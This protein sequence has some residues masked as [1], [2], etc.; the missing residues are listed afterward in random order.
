MKIFCDRER[1]NEAIAVVSRAVATKSNLAAV[2]G[3]LLV[4]ENDSLTLTGYDFETGIKTTFEC[5]IMREGS[6]VLSSQLL[7]N[8]VR[9]VTSDEVYIE[10]DDSMNCVIKAG[11]AQY[12]IKGIDPDTYPEF[13]GGVKDNVVKLEKSLFSEMVDH[14]I[15][16]VSTDQKRPVHTGVLLQM[17]ESVLTMV[18]TDGYRLAICDRNMDFEGNFRMVV[19]AKA[20]NEVRK[21]TGD[22]DGKVTIY[23][24]RRFVMFQVDEYVIVS[25]LLEGEF[26]PFRKTL[27][28]SFMT[29]TVIKTRDLAEAIE[30]VSLIITERLRNPVKINLDEGTMKISCKTEIG[31][32]YDEIS[33][34]QVG[35]DLEIGF[36]NKY[37]LDA[38][39]ASR[40]E[41]LIFKFGGTLAACEIIPKEGEDFTYLVLPVRFKDGN[42]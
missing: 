39:K 21:L 34:G 8:I 2:E 17:E 11:N 27:P 15:Y 24:S 18:A 22:G 42:N 5:Q 3:I 19:P 35:P 13:P 31:E 20:M 23:P 12:N 29:E 9:K 37:L 32:V 28:K 6:V 41:E 38:L 10:C 33:I 1:L 14:V 7:G 26:I 25:R 30:R 36:N 16:A 4:A 40:K